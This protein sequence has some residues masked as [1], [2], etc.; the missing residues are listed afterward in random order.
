MRNQE[1]RQ[2]F[3]ELVIP[4]A[5]EEVWICTDH[6]GHIQATGRDEAG[7]KQ[8]IY[9]ER[10]SLVRD[11]VKYERLRLFAEALPTLREKVAADLRKRKL[12]RR[13]VAALVV[14]LLGE[15]L[16]RI[17]NRQYAE[18]N[19]SYGLTTLHDEH[20]KIKQNDVTFEFRGKSGKEHEVALH[21]KRLARLVK[22]C[23]DLPGQHLF[24]Y[25]DEEGNVCALGS[26]NVNEYL[27]SVTEL[28]FTAKDFRTW[29]GTV[30]TAHLLHAAG[31]ANEA[32]A[33]D[34]TIVDAIKG[35]AQALG[36][37]PAVCRSHYVHPAVLESYRDGSLFQIYQAT[38]QTYAEDQ[39]GLDLDESAVLAILR[40]RRI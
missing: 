37:T 11:Y 32:K 10:W 24:Q 28:D 13:K 36:N 27:R 33:C 40:E 38:A 22:A 16:I 7:R 8:Y 2:R 14:R 5:W 17:G 15:T 21:D 20:A 23:Q 26:G 18:E 31:P 9:H 6:Q 25:L 3:A 35:T 30:S 34:Q 12:T 29:G 4:P 1:L 39:H 19:E